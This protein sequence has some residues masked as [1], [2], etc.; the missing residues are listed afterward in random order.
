MEENKKPDNKPSGPRINSY[1]IYGVIALFLLAL[2]FY[3]ISS[4]SSDP[5]NFSRFAEMARAGDVERLEVINEKFGH[6]YLKETSLEKTEY[7]DA[8]KSN[9]N[10]RPHYTFNIG[11]AEMFSKDLERLNANLAPDKQIQPEY[12]D[13]TNWLA[14][15]LS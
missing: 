1:W 4:A 15:I 7:Q 12:I 13:R 6:V 9:L 8:S 10:N 3:Q 2:N 5:I 11:P 14:P